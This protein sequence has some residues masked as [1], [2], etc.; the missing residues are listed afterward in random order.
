M[1]ALLFIFVEGK[2]YEFA[3]R[4]YIGTPEPLKCVI[5]VGA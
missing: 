3:D 5:L 4:I 1:R 2:V